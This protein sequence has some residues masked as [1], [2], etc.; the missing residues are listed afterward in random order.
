MTMRLTT[1][2]IVEEMDG[3]VR[4]QTSSTACSRKV[5]HPAPLGMPAAPLPGPSPLR[6]MR[7]QEDLQRCAQRGAHRHATVR[8]QCE[9][10]LERRALGLVIA[11]PGPK[12]GK[13]AMPGRPI[14][15]LPQR[16]HGARR[17]PTDRST[18]CWSGAT[19]GAGRVALWR[20]SCDKSHANASCRSGARIL[21]RPGP[22]KGIAA[23]G[24][25]VI[26]KRP[27]IDA[28]TA[29][30]APGRE[31]L[32]RDPS[33]QAPEASS[34][35]PPP[36]GTSRPYAFPRIVLICC[37]GVVPA[38]RLGPADRM[39]TPCRI[40]NPHSDGNRTPCKSPVHSKCVVLYKCCTG[41]GNTA[42]V[43]VLYI[44]STRTALILC[45][46]C[47][48]PARAL[49]GCCRDAVQAL[50]WYRTGIVSILTWHWHR[51]GSALVMFLACP[52][53]SPA[54]AMGGL[55]DRTSRTCAMRAA[56]PA[57]SATSVHRL[58]HTGGRNSSSEASRAR[59]TPRVFAV[60][61]QP[62]AEHESPLLAGTAAATTTDQ[63]PS[64]TQ[65]S[66][67]GD[68]T[69]DPPRETPRTRPDGAQHH[70]PKQ[71]RRQW[72]RTVRATSRHR[73]RRT[74][75]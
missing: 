4:D 43:L 7:R 55:T 63:H 75:E 33:P 2:P 17:I 15:A 51:T 71:G 70:A 38:S 74:L 14:E 61:Q 67:P 56:A 31:I 5:R 54:R 73:A 30:R 50:C 39:R 60:A 48:R 25:L 69:P 34:L 10:P 40:P 53:C 62:I 24:D 9:H 21:R 32:P 12:A 20:S 11:T 3:P 1:P 19:A 22:H 23:M 65:T 66:C 26:R 64:D 52:P 6:S 68:D 47:T 16:R 28:P 27:S 35:M 49:Y 57:T 13:V 72:R 42:T 45:P 18:T 41:N 44:Y 8:D 46:Y 58:S 37:L 36:I 29:R 59:R